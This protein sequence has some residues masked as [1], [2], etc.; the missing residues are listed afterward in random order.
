MVYRGRKGTKSVKWSYK[1]RMKSKRV[2]WGEK[3]QMTSKKVTRAKWGQKRSNEAG[4]Q[5]MPNLLTNDNLLSLI[6]CCFGDC[7]MNDCFC[8]S[9]LWFPF[10]NIPFEPVPF[11]FW[12][13]L[14]VVV[15]VGGLLGPIKDNF[16]GSNNGFF[17][18][19]WPLDGVGEGDDDTELGGDFFGVFWLDERRSNGFGLN[20]L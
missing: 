9:F 11:V 7:L 8:E 12:L 4:G 20:R 2:K 5:M 3:G 1:G 17:D 6:F 10:L 19:G 15:G 18:G 16:A 14:G 13:P